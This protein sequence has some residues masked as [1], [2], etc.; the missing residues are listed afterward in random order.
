ME[1][2]TFSDAEFS[3]LQ[4]MNSDTP[5]KTIH[6][7]IDMEKYRDDT[8]LYLCATVFGV[9]TVYSIATTTMKIWG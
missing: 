1:Y 2:T 6:I 7:T 9:F 4:S 8:T 3:D 5:K